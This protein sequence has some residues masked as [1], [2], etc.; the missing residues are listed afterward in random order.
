VVDGLLRAGVP[1]A[2]I[3]TRAAGADPRD[4]DAA[5]DRR[6]DITIVQ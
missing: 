1:A 6:V 3:D 2:V 4:G 5:L